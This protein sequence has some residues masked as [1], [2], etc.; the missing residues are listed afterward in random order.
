M[1]DDDSSGLESPDRP[2]ASN[3][4]ADTRGT[5]STIRDRLERIDAQAER[6]LASLEGERARAVRRHVREIRAEARLAKQLLRDPDSESP[7]PPDERASNENIPSSS[8]RFDTDVPMLV[9]RGG[10]V[11]TVCGPDPVAYQRWSEHDEAAENRERAGDDRLERSAD[12]QPER[13]DDETDR[14]ANDR[15]ERTTGVESERTGGGE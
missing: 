12:E 5:S 10:G 1:Y 6:L 7:E 15:L 13:T 8:D 9:E 11:T 2:N 4:I 3:E 14:T